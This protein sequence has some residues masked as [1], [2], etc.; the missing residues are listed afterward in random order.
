MI[1]FDNAATSLY[2]PDCVA[3]AVYDA[4]KTLGNPGRGAHDVSLSAARTVYLARKEISDLL[5]AENAMTIS[6]SSNATEALNTAILGLF[7]SGDAVISTVCEHNSVLR[8]LYLLEQ[9]G[10]KV[11]YIKT[12][13][14]GTL[15]YDEIEKYITANTKAFIF[16]HASNVTGNVTDFNVL[17]KLRK[18][19][20]IMLIVDGAQTAGAMPVD[21]KDFDIFCFTGHKSLLGPQGTGGLYVK[22]GIKIRP[23]KSG[24][25]G[26]HSFEKLHPDRMPEALEAGTLNCH[27]I[28][29]L[30]EAVEYINKEGVK[31]IQQQK[32]VLTY[33]FY[34]RLKE[35]R[36][37]TVYGDFSSDCRAA[38]V[39]LNIPDLDADYVSD[40]L[41]NKYKI[42]VRAGVHCAPMM[43][44]ALGTANK[45]AVRFSFGINNTTEEIDTAINAIYKIQTKG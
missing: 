21:V 3:D 19:Y 10:I 20:D 39:S 8:P 41:W 24:G 4:I 23:L 37:V 36:G 34:E 9:Q 28:A 35:L 25:S 7:S 17:K 6:F 38:V 22:P 15:L 16:T 11:D 33:Y 13:T 29:G 5:G 32:S 2:K 43:H 26:V 30:K 42:A 12:D 27:G 31:K 14:N 1:Y 18:K 40:A 45:G 44:T